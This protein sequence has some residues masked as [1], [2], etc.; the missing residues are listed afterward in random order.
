MSYDAAVVELGMSHRGELARLTRIA[1]PDVGVITRVAVEHLEFF[2]SVDE[3][4]L[5]E[6]E[7]IENLRVAECDGGVE[8]GRRARGAVCG[9]GARAGVIAFGTICARGISRREYR[10][11]R[12]G[13]VGI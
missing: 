8:C 4:A 13:R 10:R 3:I 5:A 2:S 12:H 9:S 7:L 1:A 6:R 11:A